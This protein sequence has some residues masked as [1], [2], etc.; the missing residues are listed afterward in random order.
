MKKNE[1]KK[2]KPVLWKGWVGVNIVAGLLIALNSQN[3]AAELGE[4]SAGIIITTLIVY[5]VEWLYL[6]LR[7]INK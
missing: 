5:G 6:K 7:G 4:I 1:N 2:F 3:V